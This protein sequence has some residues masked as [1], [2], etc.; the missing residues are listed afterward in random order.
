MAAST[1][2][3]P[4]TQQINELANSLSK[5]VGTLSSNLS[6]D[7][8]TKHEQHS[9]ALRDLS[10]KLIDETKCVAAALAQSAQYQAKQYEDM[11]HTLTDQLSIKVDQKIAAIPPPIVPIVN[12]PDHSATFNTINE[13]YHTIVKRLEAVE[14][15]NQDKM[16][17]I[18]KLNEYYLKNHPDCVIDMADGRR[19]FREDLHKYKLD[20]LMQDAYSRLTKAEQKIEQTALAVEKK[21]AVQETIN[22]VTNLAKNWREYSVVAVVIAH[23]I[24]DLVKHV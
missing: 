18:A 19:I 4:Y 9:Q 17:A 13:Q 20:M 22:Q 16:D 1:E 24:W 23:L 14:V 6:Q 2:I 5:S 7:A 8:A 21:P 3:G 11:V 10:A 15:N 12:I